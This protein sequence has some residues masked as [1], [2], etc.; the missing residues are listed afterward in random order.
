MNSKHQIRNI[1][2]LLGRE[3][4]RGVGQSTINADRGTESAMTDISKKDKNTIK[5]PSC[6]A[7]L[8]SAASS[9]MNHSPLTTHNSPKCKLAFTLAEV[10]I[11]LGIIGIVAALTLPSVVQNYKRQQASA[12]IKKFVSVF[13]Q[14]LLQAENDLGPRAD[15][16]S[17]NGSFTGN[18]KTSRYFIN[19]YIKPYVK[20]LNIEERSL[21]NMNMSTLRFVDGSQMSVKTGSCYD[22]YYDINGEKG[23][24]KTG[25]DIFVFIFCQKKGMCN[26]DSNQLRAFYCEANGSQYPSRASIRGYCMYG[27]D[28]RYCTLLL[29]Q[30]GWEFPKDYP[31][32]L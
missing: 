19:T 15:W 20:S 23:P 9:E 28:K 1:S 21:F 27:Y 31:L 14:A 32:N 30:N 12:R 6:L 5:Q 17:A 24:N 22:I 16:P 11:T 10:L 29:E 2:S 25:Q 26:S 4:E 8:S 3:L 7:A 18:I 13:N